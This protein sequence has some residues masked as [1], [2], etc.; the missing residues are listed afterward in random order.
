MKTVIFKG[1]DKSIDN[2]IKENRHRILYRGISIIDSD[3]DGDDNDSDDR[4]SREAQ[5]VND[6][7]EEGAKRVRRTKAQIEADKQK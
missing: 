7:K 4:L 2:I 6:D 3:D 5:I 1:E